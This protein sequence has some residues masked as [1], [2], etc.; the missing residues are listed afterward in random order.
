MITLTPL[1]GTMST[2]HIRVSLLH[3][4]YVQDDLSTS[5]RA[6]EFCWTYLE[7]R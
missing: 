6:E 4:E 2:I 5:Q 1:L 3:K 7:T